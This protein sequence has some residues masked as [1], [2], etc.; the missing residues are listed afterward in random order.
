MSKFLGLFIFIFS[1][2]AFAGNLNSNLTAP[3]AFGIDTTWPIDANQASC[4]ARAGYKAGFFR[5]ASRGETDQTGITNVLK[6]YDA[7]LAFEVYVTPSPL[8]YADRQF[9]QAYE[10]ARLNNLNLNRLWLQITSPIQWDRRQ[11]ANVRFIN[12]F[13]RAG[14]VRDFFVFYWAVYYQSGK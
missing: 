7:S 12:D 8:G 11:S 2:K 14:K 5:I 10:F 6:F 9:E 13:V 4:F 3:A 1:A